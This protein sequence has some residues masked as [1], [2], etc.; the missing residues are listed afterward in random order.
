MCP[1]GFYSAMQGAGSHN[2]GEF[3][4]IE[5]P[6]CMAEKTLGEVHA[7]STY[8]YQP[9]SLAPIIAYQPR[10]VKNFGTHVGHGAGKGAYSTSSQ[11]HEVPTHGS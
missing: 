2:D 1:K 3:V 6:H 5:A 7:L 9:P 11:R 10:F 8:A 4:K